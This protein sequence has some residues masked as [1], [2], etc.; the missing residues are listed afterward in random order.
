M[1]NRFDLFDLLIVAITIVAVPLIFVSGALLAGLST[2]YMRENTQTQSI[3]LSQ[4][5]AYPNYQRS[6]ER[7]ALIDLLE[8]GTPISI[9]ACISATNSQIMTFEK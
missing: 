1:R 7:Q 9:T 2:R 6:P 3:P 8:H 5:T 4:R